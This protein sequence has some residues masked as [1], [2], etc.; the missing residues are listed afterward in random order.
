MHRDFHSGNIFLSESNSYQHWQIGNLGLT[1]YVNDILL[2]N[3]EIYGAISCIAPEIFN[4]IKYSKESDIYS[5]GM[6]MWELT[7]GCKPFD[8]I[9]SDI[10]TDL[11][12]EIIDGKRPEITNDTPECFSNLM[13]RCW[14]SNPAKRPSV[15][16]IYETFYLW[17]FRKEHV[18]QFDEA[19]K[20]RL[21]LLELKKLCPKITEKSYA[22]PIYT[23]F[24]IDL[25][26]MRQSMYITFSNNK[27]I[28]T[29][30]ES[31]KKFFF[32]IYFKRM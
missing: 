26:N 19:E 3:N 20:R 25:L 6:I 11:I 4:C 8:N 22:G 32:R 29:F 14:N 15:K 16:E 27:I 2:N 24:S 23:K 21:E 9:E 17:L 28:Q 31:L 12:L 13:K 18:E 30:C 1:Q 10:T 5:M 7:T